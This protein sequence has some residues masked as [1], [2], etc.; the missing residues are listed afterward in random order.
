M[1]T[2]GRYTMVVENHIISYVPHG[3]CFYTCG[4]V[5]FYAE[6]AGRPDSFTGKA[7]MFFGLLAYVQQGLINHRAVQDKFFET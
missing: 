3:F 7:P 1:V 6:I 4:L 2:Q 5:S